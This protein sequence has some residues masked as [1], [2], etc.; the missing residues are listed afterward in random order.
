MNNKNE[1]SFILAKTLEHKSKSDSPSSLKLSRHEFDAT[2]FMKKI[3]AHG[4]GVKE[5]LNFNAIDI[6]NI[7]YVIYQLAFH[8]GIDAAHGNYEKSSIK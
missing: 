7:G 8:D 3:F 6:S 2:D 5:N 1:L 4:D